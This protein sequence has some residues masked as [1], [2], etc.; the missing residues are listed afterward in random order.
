[1]EI[2]YAFEHRDTSRIDAEPGLGRLREAVARWEAAESGEGLNRLSLARGPGFSVIRDRRPG[3]E[4]ADYRLG[5]VEALIYDACDSGIGLGAIC[6]RLGAKSPGASAVEEFLRSLA[7]AGLIFQEGGRYLSLAVES[8]V[9]R[10][11]SA[12]DIGDVPLRVSSLERIPVAVEA[13]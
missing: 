13:G 3:R 10:G 12:T 6:T 9:D 11:G 5:T 2:A 7:A 4:N 1:M 8:S